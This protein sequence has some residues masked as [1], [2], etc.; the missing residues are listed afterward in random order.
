MM[1]GRGITAWLLFS[2]LPASSLASFSSA[3]CHLLGSPLLEAPRSS[4]SVKYYKC[5]GLNSAS[6]FYRN[7]RSALRYPNLWFVVKDSR[8]SHYPPRTFIN[9][10]VSVLELDNVSVGQYSPVDHDAHPFGGLE[11]SLSR[12]V[13]RRN[14]SVPSRWGML[15]GLNALAELE[16]YEMANLNLT[17]D[18]NQLPRSL[19]SIS[20]YSCPIRFVDVMWLSELRNLETLVVVDSNL[21]TFARTMMPRPALRL[22]TMNLGENVLTEIPRDIG[23]DA[24]T[25]RFINMAENRVT[26]LNENTLSSLRH[27]K[28]Y[29]HMSGNPIHCDCKLRFLFKFPVIASSVQCATP[30]KLK[31][32]YFSD[33][34][35]SQLRCQ[36]PSDIGSIADTRNTLHSLAV[37]DH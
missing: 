25:L 11:D 17:R 14:S 32:R 15:A 20:I 5:T 23:E 33:L 36:R 28:T 21:K 9:G 29:V 37:W 2:I 4:S 30:Q 34:E 18:F 13:F 1:P 35:S 24:P 19:R 31:G 3:P 12:L 26:S 6:E 8:L 22:K 16:F 7:A 27:Q 10:S